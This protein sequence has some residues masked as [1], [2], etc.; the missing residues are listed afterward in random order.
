[1]LTIMLTADTLGLGYHGV[2]G[3][4]GQPTLLQDP[5]ILSF[6]ESAGEHLV[7]W[8]GRSV[9]RSGVIRRMCAG[10]QGQ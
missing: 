4:P 6:P 2:K 5:T 9:C 1:M 3:S 8:A 7:M 10:D